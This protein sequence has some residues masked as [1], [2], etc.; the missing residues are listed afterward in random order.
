MVLLHNII[1]RGDI[2]REQKM[3]FKWLKLYK[4]KAAVSLKRTY[5]LKKLNG[6]ELGDIMAGN[7]LKRFYFRPKKELEFAVLT[8]VYDKLPIRTS[9]DFKF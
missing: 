4:V 7:R 1:R 8:S 3:H 6:A 2:F 9:A 5:I